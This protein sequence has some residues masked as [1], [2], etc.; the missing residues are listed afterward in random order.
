MDYM[1]RSKMV[2]ELRKLNP[3][4]SFTIPGEEY[5]D[6][7]IVASIDNLESLKLPKGFYMNQKNGLTNKHKTSSGM[8]EC[9]DLITAHQFESDDF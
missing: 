8:Y 5:G 6:D 1:G 9:F 4:V 2:E 3:T 7:V